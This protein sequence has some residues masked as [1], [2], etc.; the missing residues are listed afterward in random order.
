MDFLI[1]MKKTQMHCAKLNF[2]IAL[3]IDF[4]KVTGSWITAY[5]LIDIGIECCLFNPHYLEEIKKKY[6]PSLVDAGLVICGMI[7]KKVRLSNDVIIFISY[8]SIMNFLLNR[9]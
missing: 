5:Q 8:Y 7:I 4:S 2:L 1:D 3:R 9:L 6:M